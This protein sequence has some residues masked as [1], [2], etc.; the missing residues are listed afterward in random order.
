MPNVPNPFSDF[1]DFVIGNTGDHDALGTWKYVLVGLFLALVVASI[2]IAVRNWRE[3]P[4]QRTVSHLATWF[5]RVAVGGLFGPGT[6]L[7]SP[8]AMVLDVPSVMLA[9]RSGR[10]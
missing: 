3:D 9:M 4:A 6:V 7:Y 10:A 2:V 5:V 8:T 1:W